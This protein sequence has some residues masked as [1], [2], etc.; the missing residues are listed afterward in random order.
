MSTG[1]EDIPG[2]LSH[3]ILSGETAHKLPVLVLA[4]SSQIQ[5][6]KR[7]LNAR[8]MEARVQIVAELLESCSSS[9]IPYNAVKTLSLITPV[10]PSFAVHAIH[11]IRFAKSLQ[12]VFH[13]LGNSEVLEAALNLDAFDVYA[14]KHGPEKLPK[15]SGS[16][17]FP[18]M[19]S[20]QARQIVR[21]SLRDYEKILILSADSSVIL[22]RVREILLGMASLHTRSVGS[23][24]ISERTEVA[25][26]RISQ[27]K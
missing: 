23:V 19:D 3:P 24:F 15:T 13:A 22:S 26:G 20:D 18:W 8:I 27:V 2:R 11:Q 21:E 14:P 10:A 7:T 9:E 4:S 17:P 12:D 6:L 16:P 1:T 5:V 25:E